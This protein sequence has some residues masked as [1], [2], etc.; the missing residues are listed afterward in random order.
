[1]DYVLLGNEGL[2]AAFHAI[3]TSSLEYLSLSKND[4]TFR[5]ISS[6][7]SNISNIPLVKLD[8]S[9]N[10]LSNEGLKVISSLLGVNY[11][12]T[13]LSVNL[14]ML[15]ISNN[16]INSIAFEIF[17]REAYCNQTL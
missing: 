17:C 8:L 16:N 1:M 15:N 13:A 11:G 6:F 5:S 2:K 7:F 3:K 4:L 10:N 14:N 12:R 9:K